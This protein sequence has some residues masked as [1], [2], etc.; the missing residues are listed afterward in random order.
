MTITARIFD[1][2]GASEI[3]THYRSATAGPG[4]EV[5]LT[6]DLAGLRLDQA[7]ARC[8]PEYSRSQLRA[9]VDEGRITVDGAVAPAKR[10]VRGNECVAL[11][12]AAAARDTADLPEDR[13]LNTVFE[14]EHLIVIDKPAGLVVH[15]GAGNRS[16]TLLNALLGHCAALAQLPRAGIVHRLDKE[17]SGLMVV[18]RT[19]EAQTDLVRQ[20]QARTVSRTYHAVVAGRLERA[21]SVDAPVGRHPTQRTRMAVVPRGRPARTHFHPLA[22]GADW[23]LVECRLETG[24]THQIRVHMQHIGHPLLGD[25]VYGG[26]RRPA[27]T[28]ASHAATLGRQALH[29]VALCLDHPVKQER[30]TWQSALPA[31]LRAL[32]QALETTCP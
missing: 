32:L 19:L 12:M 21:G 7:L 14:D 3:T 22:A 26:G 13:P 9:W 8:F 24:R 20:L 28:V 5:R 10:R 27:P 31:D 17:T 4:R 30:L 23:T 29:A 1:M 6:A 15:P 18:A 25:P 2:T 16:G 11:E